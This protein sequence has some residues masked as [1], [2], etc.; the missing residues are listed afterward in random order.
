MLI[1]NLH[2][3]NSGPGDKVVQLQK[4]FPGCDIIA[5]QLP[6]DPLQAIQVV[7]EILEKYSKD[8]IHIIGTSLGAFYAMYLST[9]YQRNYG[10]TSY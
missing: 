6:Y 8:E 7:I 1:I 9:L 2:G 3:F 4:A 10:G 5:P